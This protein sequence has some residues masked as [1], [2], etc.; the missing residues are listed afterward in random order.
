MDR[1][2]QQLIEIP[3]TSCFSLMQV[4]S[5]AYRRGCTEVILIY[6]NKEEELQQTRE[7]LIASGFAGKDVIKV[8]VVE[9]PFWSMESFATIKTI[10]NSAFEELL[11]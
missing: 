4:V 10:L 11:K 3:S 9:I 1:P 8:K 5:Y 7:F 2:K 6:P